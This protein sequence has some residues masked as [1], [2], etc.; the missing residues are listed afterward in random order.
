[1]KLSACARRLGVH[2]K[3]AWRWWQAGQL[4]ASQVAS[5]AIIVRDPAS[6]ASH[7]PVVEQVAVYAR[8]SAKE[9]RPHLE[10][11]AER[12]VAYCAAKGYHV[13]Q[14]V[15]EVGSGVNDS[16]PKFLKLLADPS[17]AVIVVEH[18]DRATRLGFR[19]LATLL[20]QQG[21]RIEV[22]S[23]AGTGREDLVADLVAIVS[24]FCAGLWTATRQAQDRDHRAR[25]DEP[26]SAGCGRARR[27]ARTGGG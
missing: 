9:N 7:P 26:A 5:G 3:T 10:G 1:M 15:K 2:D 25:T 20:E 6:T 13:C 14:V 12:L 23:V 24:S 17:I 22:I 18:Q 4:G 27:R 16:R 11:Q 8:V 19:F 21:W